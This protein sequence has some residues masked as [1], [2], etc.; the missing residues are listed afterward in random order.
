MTTVEV[1]GSRVRQARLL[2]R[3][4][5]KAVLEQMSWKGPRQ[6]RLEQ[7]ASTMLE[8]DELDRL[9]AVLRFPAAFFTASPRSRVRVDDLLFRAPKATTVSEKEYL[10]AYAAAVGDFLDEL[11]SRWSLPPVKLPRLLSGAPLAD[12]AVVVRQ[13]MGLAIDEPINYLMYE[14]ERAGVAVAVR[15]RRSRSTG[16][17][18]W[19]DT[20]EALPEKHV[21]YSTRVGEYGDRPLVVLRALDSWERTRWTLAHEIGHLVLHSSGGVGEDQELEAS[22]FASELLAPAE[23]LA[24]EV[25]AVPTPLN[26]VPLKLKWGI[27]I[28]ALARH[29]FESRL[30]DKHRYEMLRRQLYTRVNSDTGHT[31]GKTEPGWDDREPERPRLMA[32]WVEVCFGAKSAQMLAPRRLIWPEDLLEDFLAG[33]R[34]APPRRNRPS[35]GSAEVVVA[36]EPQPQ[37]SAPRGGTVVDFERFR[38]RSRT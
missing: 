13:R 11:D 32:K 30:M 21:G 15:V 9:V 10:A 2:R 14:A 4:T 22:R 29:L 7:A 19:S 38:N 6:T 8:V 25:P 36:P 27:S 34:S 18:A 1:F 35:A 5:G 12:A 17:V 33:Q 23:V 3:M 37:I 26:L 28:G 24:D 16:Q 20:D 31:W